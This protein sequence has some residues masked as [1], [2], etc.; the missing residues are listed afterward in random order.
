MQ[1]VFRMFEQGTVV[2]PAVSATQ[3]L[4]PENPFAP[5]SSE[6][7]SAVLTHSSTLN[8]SLIG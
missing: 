6:L 1:L 5:R 3:K 4:R 2:T 8:L 7:Y